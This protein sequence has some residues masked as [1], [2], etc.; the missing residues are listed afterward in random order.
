MMAAG[1]NGITSVS[2]LRPRPVGQNL[3]LMCLLVGA[4]G[5]ADLLQKNQVGVR[6]LKFVA[7]HAGALCRGGAPR[8]PHARAGSTPEWL[9]MTATTPTLAPAWEKQ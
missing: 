5:D 6:N 4:P 8:S 7:Y 3:I 9:P 1:R 2:V